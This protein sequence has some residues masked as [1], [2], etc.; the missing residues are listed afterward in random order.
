MKKYIYYND[1]RVELTEEQLV[2][3]G[4]KKESD[5]EKIIKTIY[6]RELTM[7]EFL[8]IIQSGNAQ[9]FF[10]LHDNMTVKEKEYE[11]ISF[12]KRKIVFMG[13][14][15]LPPHKM[16][17]YG[18]EG[19][20]T[21]LNSDLRKWLNESYFSTLPQLLRNAIVPVPPCDVKNCDR[22]DSLFV[23]SESEL[24]GSAIYSE[25][26]DG[27]RFDAFNTS[28]DRVYSDDEDN[29][30]AYWTRSQVSPGSAF[31]F[32]DRWGAPGITSSVGEFYVPVCFKI[33]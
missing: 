33:G 2:A 31:V 16:F 23:P 9:H 8:E 19:K 3:L 22:L 29:S 17:E 11:I 4:I 32:V 27:R 5:D 13:K 1:K 21:Y 26:M 7:P 14:K 6:G 30:A 10:K 20:Q 18:C 12:E 25:K 24:F 28:K 15:L